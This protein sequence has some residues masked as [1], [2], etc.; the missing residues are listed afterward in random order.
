MLLPKWPTRPARPGIRQAMA[1]SIAAMG[2]LEFLQSRL[3]HA[4]KAVSGIRPMRRVRL[5]LMNSHVKP[6]PRSRFNRTRL[7]E[8]G[9]FVPPLL[10]RTADASGLRRFR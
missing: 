6:P 3:L 10:L 9:R 1:V 2:K 5:G 8:G 7:Q 4:I